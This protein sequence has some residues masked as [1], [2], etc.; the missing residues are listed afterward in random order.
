MGFNFILPLRVVQG[1]LALAV[2][3]SA[4]VFVSGDKNGSGEGA[5]MVFN[6]IFTFLA[7]GY[8]VAAPLWV[9]SIHNEWAVLVVEAV[10]WVLWLA[11]F[12]ALAAII[13]GY[14][15]SSTGDQ[16]CTGISAAKAA[17]ALGAFEWLAFS[18]S[19]GLTI[20]AIVQSR[21]GVAE[22]DMEGQNMEQQQYPQGAFPMQQQVP[23]QQIGGQQVYQQ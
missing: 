19:L 1:V 11:G 10:T 23:Q 22:E 9:Q 14:H 8:L 20:Y 2:L 3:I 16:L 17:T 5:F 12:A 4:G 18:G 15:C 6:P 7:L 13:P 21:R